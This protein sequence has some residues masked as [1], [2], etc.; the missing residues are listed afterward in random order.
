[1]P[2]G[3]ARKRS[4]E[5]SG[6][7]HSTG[8]DAPGANPHALVGLSVDHANAL[9]VGVPAPPCQVM[10]V[11]NP[12]PINRAFVTDFAARREGNLPNK[13]IAEYSIRI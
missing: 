11:A 2:Q 4:Q 5:N 12:V 13:V 8:A 3:D 1:M 10:G 9:E 6:F 7:G